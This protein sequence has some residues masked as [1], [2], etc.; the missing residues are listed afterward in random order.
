M[1]LQ[2]QVTG[3][4]SI[5]THASVGNVESLSEIGEIF[6]IIACRIISRPEQEH[7]KP[8]PYAP[9]QEHWQNN[10]ALKEIYQINSPLIL[11]R[12]QEGSVRS[13][14][15]M[16]LTNAFSTHEL[17]EAVEEIY[18]RQQ[19]AFRLNLHFGLI[20]VNTETGEYRYFIPS[21][22]E[23]LFP[24]P[25]YISRHLDLTK[26]QKRLQRFNVVDYILQQR[27]NTKWKPVL[28]TNVHFNL[29]HLNYLLGT[30]DGLPDYIK[31]SKSIVSLDVHQNG[32]VYNDNLCAF[33]CL[34]MHFNGCRNMGTNANI[35][36]EKWGKHCRENEEVG[37]VDLGNFKGVS[38]DQMAH[39]ENCFDTNVYIYDL[40]EDGVAQSL[41]KSK[42]NFQTTMHMNMYEHHLS[43]IS[44]FSSYATK[45][46]CRTCERHFENLSNMLKHHRICKGRTVHQ[47]PGGFY[48]TPKTIFDKLE[49]FGIHIPK[50]ERVF[51]WF[52]VYDFEAMLVPVRGEGSESLLWF[53]PSSHSSF[54][55]FD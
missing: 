53:V 42:S 28:V 26:L 14:Y 24:R 47:F 30:P 33:R 2:V 20:L 55:E 6:T 1:S 10:D 23:T 9:E 22:N 15:N 49:E 19:H 41:Y 51:E 48:T 21:S 8:S 4:M 16:P 32:K 37:D 44:N 13:I 25:I 54:W 36:L 43:Y 46:Q 3:A 7:Y 50:R 29:F 31:S 39:F 27:P 45:F 12:H 11:Q 5:H 35:Y 17:M 52:L 34:S 38:L 40:K 18:D